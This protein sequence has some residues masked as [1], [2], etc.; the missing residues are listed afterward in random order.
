[1][2]AWT[3]PLG[4]GRLGIVLPLALSLVLTPVLARPAHSQATGSG[5]DTAAIVVGLGAIAGV[6][7]FNA[8]VLGAISLPGGATY[9]G[10]ATIPAAAAV[11]VSRVYAVTSA[12]AGAWIADYLRPADATPRERLWAV[13]A[14][15]IAGSSVFNLLTGPLGVL[16]WA[17]AAIDPIPL[18]TV[19]GSRI[20][21]V[22]TAGLGAIGATWLYDQAVGQA[23]DLTYAGVLLGGALGGVA[24]TNLLTTSKIGQLP[25]GPDLIPYGGQIAN[26]ATAVASR[27]WVI[28]SAVGGALVADWWYRR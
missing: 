16:P 1:M 11:G 15:A 10:A 2:R 3:W 22:G 14:G 24:V 12:V 8:V 23:T 28:T 4:W 27:A 17:G 7:A 21:A 5:P 19:V 18:S 26:A 20:I 6:V 9:L 25:L 13:G